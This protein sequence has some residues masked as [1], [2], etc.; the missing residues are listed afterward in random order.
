MLMLCGCV[1]AVRRRLGAL[2]RAGEAAAAD[3]LDGA[4]LRARLGA[5]AAADE[6]APRSS[7]RTPTS[8]ATRSSKV[9]RDPL[10]A[11]RPRALSPAASSTS[12]CAPSAWAGC[13]PRRSLQPIRSQVAKDAASGRHGRRRTTSRRSLKDG[14]LKMSCEDPD[15]PIN[16][17]RNLFVWRSN[18][19]GSSGKGHEYFLQAPRWARSTACRA[20][21]SARP[22][23][24]KPQ[25][26]GVARRT[27]PGRQARPAG[28]ARLP[29]V[30]DLP[31]LGRRAADGDLVREERPQHLRHAPV[32]P[33][34]L[35]GGG[36]GVAVTQSDWEIYKGIAKKF[37][38]DRGRP[39]RR[40]EGRR[41]RA[42][43][44]RHAG[45]ARPG[46]RRQGL[47]EGRVRARFPARPR[48]RSWWSSATIPTPTSASPRSGR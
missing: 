48:R 17:P 29:H 41:A 8:G 28:D 4:R 25:E 43:H 16:F 30:D 3:R 37:S 20:R 40:R 11:G 24:R 35:G 42:A 13:R 44:A 5:P 36:P 1:G 34:A 22:A 23:A 9:R 21:T 15:N 19:L 32:H 33:S 39:P 18:L 14:T 46:A 45:R 26:V 12:T 6:L 7:T 10:A 38:R 47:E 2:R 27:A 31:L